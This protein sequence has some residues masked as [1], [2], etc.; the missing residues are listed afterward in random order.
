MITKKNHLLLALVFILIGTCDSWAQRQVWPKADNKWNQQIWD[1]KWI[2]HPSAN[3]R[4]YGVFLFRKSF[5]LHTP[6]PEFIIHLS[7]DNR[8]RLFVNGRRILE[9]PAR[10][11]PNHWFY[12]SI[13][14]GPLLK[15]GKNQL[16]VQVWNMGSYMPHAQM[17]V[18]TGLIIQGEGSVESLVNTNTSWKVTRDMA[19][20]P[21]AQAGTGTVVGP[22]D[23]F[24]ASLHPFNWESV[25]FDD[26]LWQNAG[27]VGNGI[28]AG[29]FG[30]W[31]WQL[32][33]RPIP[34]MDSDTVKFQKVVRTEN[35]RLSPEVREKLNWVIPANTRCRI[36]LDNRVLTNAYPRMTV[37]NGKGARIQ[38][39]YAEALYDENNEKGNRQ[40]ITGKKIKQAFKDQWTVGGGEFREFTTLWFRTYRYVELDIQTASEAL[41]IENFDGIYTAYPFQE[42]AQIKIDHPF[43]RDIWETGWRTARL[44][45]GETYY[46]C[47][48]YEQLQYVG[49]T[50]IQALISLYV[51][52]DDRLM[53]NAIRQFAQSQLPNGL[54]QS[55]YPSGRMQI[56]PTFSLIWVS[57]IYD[58]WMHRDDE[59]FIKQYLHQIGNV[60]NWYD[61]HL[62]SRNLLDNMSWW[63]FVDWSFGE[64]SPHK[65]IG[66]VP[67]NGYQGE[68][69]LISLQYAYT[70]Q[71]AEKIFAYFDQEE[72]A[73]QCQHQ[74]EQVLS[75]VMASSW[76]KERRM[77]Q[78]APGQNVF[79]QH[80]QALAI[81]C[82]LFSNTEAKSLFKRMTNTEAI[83]PCTY[84]FRFY[85]NRVMDELNL[86]QDYLDGLVHWKQMLDLGLTTFAETPEPTRSDCHAWSASPNYDLLAFIAGIKPGSPGFK[87][88]LVQPD[89]GNLKY[90]DVKVPHPEGLIHLKMTLNKN[91]EYDVSV[92]LPQGVNG[93]FLLEGQGRPLHPGSQV[94]KIKKQIK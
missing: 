45:A 81:L 60:L 40:E 8:Y 31:D 11:D 13:D 62:N 89:P 90:L 41:E 43:V 71:L 57:M 61:Q 58:Y 86:G 28:P 38:L 44:C 76:D 6:A 17:S 69:T 63:N 65:P 1:A 87:T 92:A 32:T 25:Y 73:K 16:A 23:S 64:W 54:T 70:L 37:S 82:G 88:V 67:Q 2:L 72:R 20:K 46:D 56:I 36:L 35:I 52:G 19:F 18:K 93:E 55:R 29:V 9:G 59:A 14:I 84:Y 39:E 42:L 5:E 53:R 48:Y 24:D 4:D 27:M 94:F 68:T 49:D 51:S 12:E 33:P 80:T 50:R 75:A 30:S 34:F 77:L 26:S 47:P 85:L 3:A 78:D 7:A 66:G 15:T 10:S 79:S 22:G 74:A 91:N 83:I 21:L